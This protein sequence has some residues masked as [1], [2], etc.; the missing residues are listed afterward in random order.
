MRMANPNDTSGFEMNF[1]LVNQLSSLQ[2]LNQAF[3]K[4][5]AEQRIDEKTLFQLNLICDEL[6]TNI[7]SYGYNDN[8]EH[9]I[10]I[11]LII[12][13]SEWILTVR[14]DGCPFNPLE[15][16]NPDL[17]LS[18]EDRAVGGLGIHFVNQLMDDMTYTRSEPYNILTMI[19]N[20]TNRR[21]I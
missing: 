18:I 21:S 5:F 4:L 19:K 16:S 9:L 3:N 20:R 11:Q 17:M 13:D 7:V 10:S 1:E 15:R 6:I 2:F 14:D 8:Q 12:T